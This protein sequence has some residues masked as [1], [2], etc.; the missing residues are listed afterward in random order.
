[1][2]LE[3]INQISQHHR[4]EHETPLG[5]GNLISCPKFVHQCSVDPLPLLIKRFLS[6]ISI[7]YY[8]F[9]MSIQIYVLTLQEHLEETPIKNVERV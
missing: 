6:W 7:D 4:N 9:L 8:S 1:M 2:F 5:H 3:P